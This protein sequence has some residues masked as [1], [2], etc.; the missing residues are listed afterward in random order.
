[1]DKPKV[2]YIHF[3]G[4]VLRKSFDYKG[5]EITEREK[6]VIDALQSFIDEGNPFVKQFDICDR[7]DV[8]WGGIFLP[9]Y[10]KGIIV[11]TE[12]TEANLRALGWEGEIGARHKTGY[13]YSLS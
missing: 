12:R 10:E 7:A 13:L 3:R 8:H 9:L 4:S 1:M 5:I 6:K 11:K 2:I